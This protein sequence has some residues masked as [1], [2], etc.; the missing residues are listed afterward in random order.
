MA[1]RYYCRDPHGVRTITEIVKKKVPQWKHRKDGFSQLK[2]V[3]RVLEGEDIFCSMETGGVKLPVFTHPFAANTS[4]LGKKLKLI[5]KEREAA[6]PAIIT[7]EKRVDSYT[8]LEFGQEPKTEKYGAEPNK[9][10]EVQRV[11]ANCE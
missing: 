8:S 3:A 1:P 11:S 10:V 2:L 6:E 9:A 4:A 5:K 7:F